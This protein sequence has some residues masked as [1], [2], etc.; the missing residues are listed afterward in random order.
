MRQ[1]IGG[2]MDVG[3]NVPRTPGS[4][5]FGHS[6]GS[7]IVVS[8]IALVFV[9]GSSVVARSTVSRHASLRVT[10]S[11][12][13]SI[14]VVDDVRLGRT[15]ATGARTF[16]NV[17]AGR[18]SVVVRQPGYSDFR[19]VV[20]FR[21]GATA[22]VVPKRV[23]LT[24]EAERIRQAADFLAA[25]G[26]H[27]LAAAEYRRAMAI[28]PDG[29]RDAEIGLARSLLALKDYDGSTAAAEQLAST[30]PKHLE[31]Q[32][33]LANVLRERGLYDEAIAV[34]RRAIAL[35]PDRSPE[36]H[37]GLAILLN[38][39]GDL[40]GAAT[41]MAR[42]IAQNLD[43]EPILYQVYGGILER[44]ERRTDA[45]AAYER[46]LALAPKSALAPAVQSVVDQL[47]QTEDENPYA[48]T[49]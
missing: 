2:Y 42:A 29:F 47:K 45:V 23:K 11:V 37:A 9:F 12:A 44:L 39:R 15:D 41:E 49:P 18:R 5:T 48:P 4:E 25:D 10:G 38:E 16:A 17:P 31:S 36:A 33:V 21:A 32:T 20:V 30:E 19:R 7:T 1:T 27:V 22:A 35:A 34:Y 46:F 13:S 14:V 24:D 26:K 28:R 6:P 8:I 43:A 40:A 3:M